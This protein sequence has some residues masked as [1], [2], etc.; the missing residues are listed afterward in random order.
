MLA[1]LSR[2]ALV[3]AGRQM[4]HACLR[5]R[6][7]TQ[8][9]TPVRN[10]GPSVR[11]LTS[12]APACQRVRY[13]RFDDPNDP[14]QQRPPDDPQQQ[15]PPD[16]PKGTSTLGQVIVPVVLGSVVLYYVLH[17]EKV[18]ET[19]RWR[20]MDTSE[21]TEA[22]LWE[23]S[24]GALIEEYRGK[25]LPPN[26]PLTVHVHDVASRILSA[27]HLGT[28]QAADP[29]GKPTRRDVFGSEATP[30][31]SDAWDPDGKTQAGKQKVWNLFVVDDKSVVNAMAAPGSIVVFTG[32]LPVA[33]DKDGLAAVLAHE[34]GHVVLR[35]SVENLS[36]MKVLFGLAFLLQFLG[37]PDLMTSVVTTYIM[38]LPNS[39][40]K[41][42][43]ADTIGLKLASRACFN[44][45][46]A[47]EMFQRLGAM[48]GSGGFEFIRTH[49][50]SD[51]R[52][53]ALQRQLPEA[54]DVQAASSDCGGM[55]DQFG[56]FRET[57]ATKW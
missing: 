16:G 15:K 34:V 52:V 33:R 56:A 14:Q 57:F 48:E 29:R 55:A 25:I 41:E 54:Y 21:K 38:E 36:S 7:C 24:Y 28:L 53:K 40:T 39:R 26:H 9:T 11:L 47:P 4:G 45:N 43:E 42:L 32:I 3:P 1:S 22:A 12:S 13:T 30:E 27:N 46:S 20:F 10:L 44:P 2:R 18:P 8:S 50:S 6:P 51:K 31:M 5:A 35:H 19:G 37:F 17:L 49:P 23:S